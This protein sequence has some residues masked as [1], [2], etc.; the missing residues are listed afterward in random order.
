MVRWGKLRDDMDYNGL[1]NNYNHMRKYRMIHIFAVLT[2]YLVQSVTWSPAVL[3]FVYVYRAYN[4]F[5]ASGLS[6]I[7]D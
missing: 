7:S 5:T 4:L 3:L 1:I 2:T 6:L